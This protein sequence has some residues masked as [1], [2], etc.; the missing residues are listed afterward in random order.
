MIDCEAQDLN[1]KGKGK[2][3]ADDDENENKVMGDYWSPRLA[4][5]VLPSIIMNSIAD[6]HSS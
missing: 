5:Y 4:Q 1:F 6:R 2:A 3:A